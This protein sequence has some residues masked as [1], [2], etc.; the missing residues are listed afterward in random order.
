MARSTDH[1]HPFPGDPLARVPE[2]PDPRVPW[3]EALASAKPGQRY[4]IAEILFDTVRQRCQE[5]GYAE[6][7][8]IICM[9]NDSV[10]V[11]VVG[12][13]DRWRLLEREYAWF[14]R[15]EAIGRGMWPDP[16]N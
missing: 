9:E 10:G 2:G 6:G 1:G 13:D 14:I 8:G 12:D 4:R 16:E 7:D 15:V 5:L 11:W 3:T